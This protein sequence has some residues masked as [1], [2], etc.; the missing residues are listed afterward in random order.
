MYNLPVLRTQY[1]LR[2]TLDNV[3]IFAATIKNKIYKT[4]EKVSLLYQSILLL[5]L[6]FLPDVLRF[7]PYPLL[8]RGLPLAIIL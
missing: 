3:V 8:F 5:Y 2:T 7:L 4:Q 6:F 1:I